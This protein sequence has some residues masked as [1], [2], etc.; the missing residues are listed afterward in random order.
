MSFGASLF[1]L[2]DGAAVYLRAAPRTEPLLRELHHLLERE[3]LGAVEKLV[4]G[5]NPVIESGL[6]RER[7][8][9]RLA[10]S[11]VHL[12]D[13]QRRQSPGRPSTARRRGE[14]DRLSFSLE[15]ARMVRSPLKFFASESAQ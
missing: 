4:I 7:P 5:V 13:R 2:R 10:A 12:L 6:G 8:V 9:A 15:G 14:K 11:V 3:R 1:S